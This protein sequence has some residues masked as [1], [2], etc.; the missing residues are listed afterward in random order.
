MNLSKNQDC[1]AVY[2]TLSPGQAN[3]HLLH[4]FGG[5]WLKGKIRGRRFIFAGYP[6]LQL[7]PRSP[8]LPLD[9]LVS[10]KID[11]ALLDAFEG[12]HYRRET[13]PVQTE[14]GVLPCHIYL[15]ATGPGSLEKSIS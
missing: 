1:L 5:Q 14:A 7:N 15:H 6:A 10:E 13:V 3:H 4:P 9:I 11:W 8:W 2:G 12:E